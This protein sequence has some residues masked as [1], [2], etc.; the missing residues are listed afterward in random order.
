MGEAT[1]TLQVLKWSTKRSKLIAGRKAQAG[2]ARRAQ[3][4]RTMT[5]FAR[6]RLESNVSP[7]SPTRLSGAPLLTLRAALNF[8]SEPKSDKA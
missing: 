3:Q 5:I 7:L 6:Q 1:R 4:P 8:L 2:R